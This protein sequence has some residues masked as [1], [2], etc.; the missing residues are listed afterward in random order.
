MLTQVALLTLDQSDV[1][2]RRV[3]ISCKTTL[4]SLREIATKER[5]QLE[6]QR[7]TF[8]M[9]ANQNAPLLCIP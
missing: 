5:Q 6:V 1:T 9:D 7:A 8:Q 2:Q 4:L 3:Q